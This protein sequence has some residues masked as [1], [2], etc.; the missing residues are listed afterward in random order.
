MEKLNKAI[1]E[2]RLAALLFLT[3]LAL[4]FFYA[5]LSFMLAVTGAVIFYVLLK[6]LYIRLYGR[7]GH[8][9]VSV[10]LVLLL[11]LVLIIFPIAVIAYYAVIDASEILSDP[12]NVESIISVITFGNAD[13]NLEDFL[14]NNMITI[15]TA[16][17]QFGL[18]L[19]GLAADVAVNLCIMYISLF[20]L[21][22]EHK[23]VNK[24]MKMILPFNEKNSETLMTKFHHVINATFAGNIIVSIIIGF[25]FALVLYFFGHGQFF[26][27]AIISTL[28]SIIPIVGLIIIWLPVGL[29]YLLVGNIT[30][31]VIVLAWG[32]FLSF[33]FDGYAR[34][35]VQDRIADVHPFVSL[36]GLLMGITFF[37]VTGLIIGPVLI[38]IF[39]LTAQMF[40]QEYLPQWK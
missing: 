24:A 31:G 18:G 14:R 39:F 29:Y 13:T 33:V 25:L 9:N 19:F 7:I 37:G 22:K 26:F 20:F 2:K 32:A 27:W 17:T 4:F 3:V 21:I 15:S 5:S 11:S 6:P 10:T 16:A 40:K 28:A 35:A 1:K 30:V 23:R 38:A 34:Q 36:I 12:A 8:K